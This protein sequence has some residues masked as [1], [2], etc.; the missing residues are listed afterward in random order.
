MIHGSAMLVLAVSCPIST[1]VT[2]S[3]A[4]LAHIV[5]DG[6]FIFSKSRQCLHDRLVRTVVV[7]TREGWTG[8]TVPDGVLAP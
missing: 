5:I 2:S 8:R 1:N 3:M 6:L 7:G 4:A